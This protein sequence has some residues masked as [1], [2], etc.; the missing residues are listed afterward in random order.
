MV[1]S[2]NP[3]APDVEAVFFD[4]GGVLTTPVSQTIGSWP[5]RDGI[6]PDSFSSTPRAWLGLDA[7]SGTPIHRLEVGDLWVEEFDRSLAAEPFTVD[8]G[9]VRHEGPSRSLFSE[10]RPDERRLALVAELKSRGLKLGLLSI[11]W[12]NT[13][14]RERIDDLFDGIVISCEVGM[15]K[16]DPEIVVHCLGR[17]RVA[18]GAAAFVDDAEPTVAGARWVGMHGIPHD[19][20]AST[21]GALGELGVEATISR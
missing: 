7:P 6:D 18:A 9:P 3:I 14:P 2:P 12:G 5:E 8:G 16:P 19:S 17:M 1:E 15:P 4:Y 10:L 20:E 13:Y 11:S 21:R